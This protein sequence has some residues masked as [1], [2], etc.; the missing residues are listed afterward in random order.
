MVV[1]VLS[2]E[3][4]QGLSDD[5]YAATYDVRAEVDAR[6]YT[7]QACVELA[8]VGDR[9]IQCANLCDNQAKELFRW[10]QIIPAKLS[11]LIFAIYNHEPVIFPVDID[12][13]HPAQEPIKTA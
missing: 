9:T 11:K 7:L 12:E 5:R 10:H 8:G 3:P 2:I 6:V 1:R 13:S 4:K